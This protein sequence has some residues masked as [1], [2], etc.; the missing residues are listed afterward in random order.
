MIKTVPHTVPGFTFI[1][2]E[3]R[4]ETT[5]ESAQSVLDRLEESP[6][7]VDVMHTHEFDF[8]LE[9]QHW[10]GRGYYIG[11]HSLQSWEPGNYYVLL[12]SPQWHWQ[13]N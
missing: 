5:L 7:V 4:Y 1:E 3:P 12:H 10:F 6:D 13:Q 2:P 8:L 11:A 9:L